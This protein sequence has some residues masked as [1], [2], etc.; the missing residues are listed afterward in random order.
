[1]TKREHPELPGTDITQ[2]EIDH[3]IRIGNRLRSQAIVAAI[4]NLFRG[5]RRRLIPAANDAAAEQ[6]EITP[7]FAH[8]VKSSLAAIRCSG[9]LLKDEPN[10]ADS[11]R[12]RFVEIILKE[13]SRLEALLTQLVQHHPRQAQA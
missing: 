6:A 4:R 9:E 11:D 10:L 8:H 12:A 5:P 2:D 1:M 7:K 13:E 3:Y